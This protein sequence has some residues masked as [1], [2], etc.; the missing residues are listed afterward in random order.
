MNYSDEKEII[1]IVEAF[2]NGTISRDSWRHA[3]HLIV[4]NHYLSH[5]EFTEA[6]KKMRGGIF[7]LLESFGVDLSKEMPYHVTLTIFWLK[8]VE[9]FRMSRN[10]YSVVEICNELTAAFDKDYP[11]RF[12]SRDYLFS[13]K[14]RNDFVE[15]D[16][17]QVFN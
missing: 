3:E 17:K 4:A 10:G 11:L 16:L 7:N 2:E 1:N 9:E 13:E 14:A 12:Y 15:A 6:Y 8:T 5:H